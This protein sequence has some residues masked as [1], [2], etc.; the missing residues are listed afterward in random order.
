[1]KLPNFMSCYYELNTWPEHV[2]L[3]N[4]PTLKNNEL[5]FQ[6]LPINSMATGPSLEGFKQ[7]FNEVYGFRSNLLKSKVFKINKDLVNLF[8]L[9]DNKLDEKIRLPFPIIYLECKIP[10][11][12][13]YVLDKQVSDG[14]LYYKGVLIIEVPKEN[15]HFDIDANMI[16]WV[17]PSINEAINA[18]DVELYTY[19]FSY[20]PFHPEDFQ[21]LA[22]FMSQKYSNKKTLL[23]ID[24]LNQLKAFTANFLDFLN[25][26]EVKLIENKTPNRKTNI[27]K[28]KGK[29]TPPTMKIKINGTLLKYIN[30]IKTGRHF[31]YSHRFWVRGHWRHLKSKVFVNRQG[32]KIW[33]RPHIKGDGILIGDK[34]YLLD[35]KNDHRLATKKEAEG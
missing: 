8:K 13:K 33:I 7:A 4:H 22:C 30:Q 35:R 9:T 20:S 31:N 26:P 24:E 29:P 10:I 21:I 2:K 11:Y 17:W 14:D 6:R 5:P 32:Q 12:G 3:P 16:K 27:R 28:R 18:Q 15:I 23:N 19:S 1:M 34:K 25:D